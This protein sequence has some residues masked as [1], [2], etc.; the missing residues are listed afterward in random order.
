MKNDWGNVA[1]VL[2]KDAVVVIPTDTIYGLVCSA[3]SK[4]AVERVY[5]IKGRDEGKA[6]IVLVNSFENLKKFGVQ[7]GEEGQKFLRNFWPG[8]LSVILPIE[9]KKILKDL[10]YLHRGL[11]TIAFR[12]IPKRNKNLFNLIQ[13][14]GPLLAPSANPQG[15]PHAKKRSEAKKYFGTSVD[16]YICVGTRDAKPSTLVEYKNNK[17]NVLRQ[18]GVKITF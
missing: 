3:Y 9:D 12:M 13:T 16:C 17:F 5:K 14:V 7:L 8:K 6:C 11:G 1:G 4:K 10:K 18:G 2:K 15:M